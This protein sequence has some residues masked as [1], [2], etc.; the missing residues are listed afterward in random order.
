MDHEAMFLAAIAR[1]RAD[2]EANF[3]P[4]SIPDLSP[5]PHRVIGGTPT[6][7]PT[8]GIVRKVREAQ[9]PPFRREGQNYRYIDGKRVK[10]RGYR[11]WESR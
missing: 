6:Q 4:H 3:R 10:L 1:H 11:R 5:G 2:F 7:F 9:R 8:A